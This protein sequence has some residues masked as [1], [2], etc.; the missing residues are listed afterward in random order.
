M[1]ICQKEVVLFGL[2]HHQALIDGIIRDLGRSVEPAAF[3]VR[4][5]LA[6]AVTNAYVHG[7][8]GDC[9]KPIYIRYSLEGNHL[10]LQVEDVGK[11]A[12]A[13]EIPLDIDENRLLDEGGRGL[14]LIRSFSDH[15]EM[16]DNTINIVKIL[17]CL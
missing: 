17:E 9:T 4:L 7:N 11:K 6:E 2:D 10:S 5:I 15:V 16:V 1:A 8:G 3:D 12:G 14:F 13:W